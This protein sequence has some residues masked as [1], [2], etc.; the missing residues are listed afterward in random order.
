MTHHALTPIIDPHLHLWQRDKGE[1]GWLHKLA[2]QG[3]IP[4]YQDFLA[5]DLALSAPLTLSG[6]VH[7][8]A[9][10]NNAAPW[11]ELAW[12]QNIKAPPFKYI[13]ALMAQSA[14]VKQVADDACVGVRLIAE[15]DNCLKAPELSGTLRELAHRNKLFEVQLNL[16]CPKQLSALCQLLENTPDLTCV[17]EH[18][19]WVGA[20]D[21]THLA[22]AYDVLSKYPHCYIKLSGLE[23]TPIRDVT[24]TLTHALE[25]ALEHFG[26]ERTMLASNFPLALWQA[27]DFNAFWQALYITFGSHPA[28]HAISFANAKR[29]YQF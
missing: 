25:Q 7:I 23:M 12:L 1:Y 27:A 15:T 3:D 20:N 16:S 13:G 19:G 11:Q 14:V 5:D 22:S 6:F 26:N 9:G 28:W 8:E 4:F 18:G 17:L 29:I 21:L 24:S 2:K 10:F